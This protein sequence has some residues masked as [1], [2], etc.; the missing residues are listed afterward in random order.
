MLTP[1]REQ[2][3]RTESSTMRREPSYASYALL[4]GLYQALFGSFIYLYRRWS[5]PLEQLTALDLS[6]LGLATMRLS[7]LVSEDEITAILREPLIDES[8]GT[9]QPKGHGLRRSLGKLVLCPTCTGTWIASFLA[10]ALHLSPRYARPFLAIMAASGIS[11]T[12]DAVLSL[13]YTDR[14]LM[15]KEQQG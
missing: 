2:E 5:H 9:K 11:Q 14:D 3:E 6:L 10:Y 12:S 15:R 8:G 7:K 1:D 13:V 4:I